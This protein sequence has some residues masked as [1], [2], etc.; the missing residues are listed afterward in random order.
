MKIIKILKGITV[1]EYKLQKKELD[2]I[3]FPARTLGLTLL[4]L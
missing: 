4:N 3:F 2:R 1:F